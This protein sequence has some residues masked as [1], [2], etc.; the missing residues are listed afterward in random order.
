MGLVY[1]QAGLLY[2]DEIKELAV[3]LH[4]R[5]AVGWFTES[6]N[7]NGLVQ[8]YATQAEISFF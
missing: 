1:Y 4:Y 3:E 5:G 6:N 7:K 2:E 8:V